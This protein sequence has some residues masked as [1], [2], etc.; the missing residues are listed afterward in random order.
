MA[1][2]PRVVILNGGASAGKTTLATGFRD[3]RAAAGDFW[4]VVGIDDFLAKLPSAWKST[5]GE[6]GAFAEVGIRFET[7]P[8][9]PRVRVGAVGRQLLRAYLGAVVAAARMGLNVLVDE[10]VIDKKSWDDWTNLL[11]GLDV[12]WVA[13]RC[14]PEVAEERNQVRGVRFPGIAAAQAVTS[15]ENVTYDFEID[16]TTQPPDTVLFALMRGLGY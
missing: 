10:V 1:K 7:T 12:V 5:D 8:D 9:G 16:T 11:Q 14:A 13:V 4:L 6:G 3:Q 15:H 2:M